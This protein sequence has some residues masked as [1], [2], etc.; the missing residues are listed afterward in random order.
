M[1][2]SRS[3]QGPKEGRKGEAVQTETKSRV[4]DGRRGMWNKREDAKK[5]QLDEDGGHQED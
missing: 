2:R 1:R 3:R 4:V 5:Y